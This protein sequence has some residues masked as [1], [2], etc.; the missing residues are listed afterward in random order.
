[1]IK[2]RIDCSE[3]GKE[4]LKAKAVLLFLKV[5]EGHLFVTHGE[6]T[7][8]DMAHFNE[9]LSEHKREDKADARL[10]VSEG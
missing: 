7:G 10:V 1:M 4:T 6:L 3:C 5:E 8:Q 9:W 2:I